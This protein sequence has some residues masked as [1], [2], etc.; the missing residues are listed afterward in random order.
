MG[1]I[2]GMVSREEPAGWLA[3]RCR[4]GFS[5]ASCRVAGLLNKKQEIQVVFWVRCFEV[6]REFHG[7]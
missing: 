6:A 4:L 5:L 2:P 7:G 1:A 3:L